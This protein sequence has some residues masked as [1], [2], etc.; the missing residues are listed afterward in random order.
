MKTRTVN[1]SEIA[2]NPSMSLSPS[3]YIY[4]DI[5]K[6]ADVIYKKE[7]STLQG[8]SFFISA[9]KQEVEIIEP[10]NMKRGFTLQELYKKIDCHLIEVV[11]LKNGYIMIID[12]EGKLYDDVK[13][14]AGGTY[15]FMKTYGNFDVICGNAVVCK[16]RMLK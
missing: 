13:V 1:F 9:E 14:N 12:E 15:L 11:S 16:S 3:D 4:T 8:K 6:V 5:E 10:E 2:E 7:Q